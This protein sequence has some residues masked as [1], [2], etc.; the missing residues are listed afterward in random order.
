MKVLAVIGVIV[1]IPLGWAA[2]S[3][4]FS[5]PER[6]EE[7]AVVEAGVVS[8][9]DIRVGDCFSLP[10]DSVVSIEQA[11]LVPCLEP[12]TYEAYAE[13]V[14]ADK[15]QAPYPGLAV[16]LDQSDAFCLDE[17][18]AFVDHRWE[19]SVLD[20]AYLYPEEEGWQF[21]DRTVLC[22]IQPTSD[23]PL[24]GSMRGAGI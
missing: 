19:T 6:D 22:L 14:Y 3:G 18:E 2:L 1:F 24:T 23:D 21:G 16:I 12:H 15:S 4:A 10:D 17:F 7:G 8:A 11:E 5:G 9:F 20:F 13:Y